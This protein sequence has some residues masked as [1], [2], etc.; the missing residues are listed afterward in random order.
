V[1][2][3]TT[4]TYGNDGLYKDVSKILLK[5]SIIH[6]PYFISDIMYLGCYLNINVLDRILKAQH[7]LN[8]DFAT[9]P[10]MSVPW[11]TSYCH[12]FGYIYAGVEVGYLIRRV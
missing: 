6:N 5:V 9:N 1:V 3:P 8:L 12:E 7:V 10:Y 11:C 4:N 2:N